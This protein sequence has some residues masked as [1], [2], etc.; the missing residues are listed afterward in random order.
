[1]Q[2]AISIALIWLGS[3]FLFNTF[4]IILL[5]L[6]GLAWLG[7]LKKT[8]PNCCNNYC[9]GM[10]CTKSQAGKKR[11]WKVKVLSRSRSHCTAFGTGTWS[12]PR[13]IRRVGRSCWTHVLH[14]LYAFYFLDAADQFRKSLRPGQRNMDLNFLHLQ[15]IWG[16]WESNCLRGGF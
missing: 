1:M 3:C 12:C 4:L 6:K 10:E 16:L 15:L 7:E 2:G 5:Q 14:F 13:S 9:V 8:E 11:S